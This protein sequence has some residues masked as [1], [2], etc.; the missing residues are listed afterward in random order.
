MTEQRVEIESLSPDVEL[1]QQ[2]V[3]IGDVAQRAAGF[4]LEN[5]GQRDVQLLNADQ[6]SITADIGSQCQGQVG[7]QVL[8]Q[9]GSK[10][11]DIGTA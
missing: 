5:G 1:R 8:G 2:V 3:D 7:Q 6:R 11:P 4:G 9:V 10:Q